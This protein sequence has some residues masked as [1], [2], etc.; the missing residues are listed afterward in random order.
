MRLRRPVLLLTAA[1]LLAAPTVLAVSPAVP[2][3]GEGTPGTAAL[4]PAQRSLPTAEETA[5]GERALELLNRARLD[6]GLAPLAG[7]GALE[8][9]A[10]QHA[11]EMAERDSVS[12]HSYRYGVGTRS[13]IRLAFPGILQYAENVAR[14]RTVAR[15]HAALL[16]SRG[17]RRNRLDP[18][19]THVGIGVAR[20]GADSLYLAEVFVR[21]QNPALL[22]IHTLY[23][24]ADPERL[25]RDEPATGE[26]LSERVTISAPGPDNPEYW[27]RRGIDA[28]AAGRFEEAVD[29]FE[30]ALEIAP[31]YDFAR[32][33]LARSLLSAGRPG[34]AL[35]IL[36]RHLA[37][38]PGDLD[39]WW[40]RGA[41]ALL[42]GDWT[43]AERAFRTVLGTRQREAGG[44]YNLGLALECQGRLDEAENAYAQAVHLDP[45]MQSAQDALRRLRR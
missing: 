23:T 41:A 2:P 45:E 4:P 34:D 11:R 16:A 33:N 42:T 6:E 38:S 22:S 10:Y 20:A 44:W 27:T 36:D 35:V 43:L 31:G 39:A 9:L 12:H 28:F 13:R 15:L 1:A 19:F 8:L 26:V 32:F 5:A 7:N 21:V 25:P 24:E 37:E 17:H 40:T 14:N 18:S 3:A 30:R 29:L